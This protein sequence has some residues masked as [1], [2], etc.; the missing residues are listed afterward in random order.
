MKRL[1]LT[2]LVAAALAL[3][4]CKVSG[5]TPRR[6]KAKAPDA[7]GRKLIVVDSSGNT[8]GKLRLHKDRIRVYGPDMMQFGMIAR[9]E[10]GLG[11]TPYGQTSVQYLTVDSHGIWE[12]AESLRIE[13]VDRG[14]AVFGADATLIGYVEFSGTW[15]FRSGYDDSAQ[16]VTKGRAVMAG[17]E[18]ICTGW[19]AEI[20]PEMTLALC[21]EGL[22]LESR[23]LLGAWLKD[24]ETARATTA[25]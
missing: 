20:E 23:T 16:W 2:L 9:D 24:Q 18:K 13:P 19:S 11:F 6:H 1:A 17:A 5:Q 25:K 7:S 3:A 14:W 15:T 4:G 10:T 12:S 21:I 22:P 8:L